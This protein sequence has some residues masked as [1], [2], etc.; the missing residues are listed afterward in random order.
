MPKLVDFG[1]FS[2]SEALTESSVYEALLL[3]G[4]HDGRSGLEGQRRST[5]RRYAWNKKR[6]GQGDLPGVKVTSPKRVW[7]V[8]AYLLVELGALVGG[9]AAGGDVWS[10]PLQ[11]VSSAP[12]TTANSTIRV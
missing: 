9:A 4:R 5:E 3:A 12:I 10:P 7:E 2:P 6:A 8:C 11:P 1:G